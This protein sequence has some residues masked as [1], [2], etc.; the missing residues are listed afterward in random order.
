MPNKLTKIQIA[1]DQIRNPAPP[2]SFINSYKDFLKVRDSLPYYRFGEKVLNSLLDLSLETWDT[3]ERISRISLLQSIR[4][5]SDDSTRGLYSE[6]N[7]K[8][9]SLKQPVKK[10]LFK[11]FKNCFEDGHRLTEKQLPEAQKICNTLLLNIELEVKEEQWLCDNHH[12][13]I[14]ILNRLLRYPKQSKIITSWVK[15][16]FHRDNLRNRRAELISWILDEEPDYNLDF[17]I[18]V[19]DFNYFNRKDK[20]ALDRVKESIALH[21]MLS[22]RLGDQTESDRIFDIPG[23][24]LDPDSE[25]NIQPLELSKRF[26]RVPTKY[27]PEH[28]ENIPEFKKME[29]HFV[30]NIVTFHKVTMMWATSYSRLSIAKKSNLM[31]KYYTPEAENTFFRICHRSKLI[32][33]LEWLKS[34]S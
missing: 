20:E 22:E 26:Y 12:R 2:E 21:Q 34:V 6:S 1:I 10:K 25:L 31:I 29:K 16:N 11:V 33:P 24:D 30:E 5:Y 32:K 4:R 8:L 18:L 19:D 3:S 27:S 7:K 14:I 17:K 15:D 28:Y 23:I 13:S 9:R